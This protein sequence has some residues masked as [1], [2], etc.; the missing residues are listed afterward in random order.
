MKE[1]KILLWGIS[2]ALL[3]VV[4]G[5]FGA[6]ALK[7]MVSLEKVN[8][9]ETGVRYQFFHALGLIL[10]AQYAQSKARK[11]QNQKGLTWTSNFF[12]IGM[13][14]FSG[15]LYLLTLQPLCSFNYSKIIGPITPIGGLFL[16][17]AWGRW[18]R[19]VWL[20]KVDK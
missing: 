7:N 15:S 20:Y 14:F 11:S 8:I 9:F 6:H 19:D 13:L 12:L 1:R 16:I 3:A 18:F 10:Y 4:F 5:A 17:L 2:L